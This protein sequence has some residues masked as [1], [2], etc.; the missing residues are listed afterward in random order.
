[1]CLDV[2]PLDGQVASKMSPMKKMSHSR[3]KTTCDFWSLP[4]RCPPSDRRGFRGR[5]WG[6][7]GKDLK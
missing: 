4:P 3:H 7:G 2:L 1:M 5:I 6:K